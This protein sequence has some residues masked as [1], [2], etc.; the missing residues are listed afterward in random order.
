[1]RG[2]RLLMAV[3]ILTVSFSSFGQEGKKNT[4][5]DSV[6]ILKNIIKESTTVSSSA[7]GFAGSPSRSWYSF[8]YLVSIATESELLA[9]TRD[10]NPALRLYAYTGLVHKK[11]KNIDQVTQRLSRDKAFVKT[12]S[13]CI[14][15]TTSVDKALH[16]TGEWYYEPA[17]S[18]FIK[19]LKAGNTYR[20]EL[21]T[22]LSLNKPIKR[23]V[24]E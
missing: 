9:M 19:I 16:N 18:D 21:F 15:G 13:G 12:L 2:I 5:T 23:F 22:A 20:S 24:K 3:F 10:T 6:T 7:V 17:V 11:Y 4:H 1:M 8:A 14:M